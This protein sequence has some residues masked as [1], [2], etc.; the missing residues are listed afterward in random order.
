[1]EWSHLNW[2][3]NGR[4]LSAALKLSAI[5]RSLAM[6]LLQPHFITRNTKARVSLT[7]AQEDEET[8]LLDITRLRPRIEHDFTATVSGFVGYRAEWA[9]LSD[10]DLAR[11]WSWAG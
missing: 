9:N 1:A 7:L 11:C 6:Q 8:Y 10:I 3:G 2:F 5:H 4:Q